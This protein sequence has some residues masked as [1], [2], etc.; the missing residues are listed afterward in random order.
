[1]THNIVFQIFSNINNSIA[2]LFSKTLTNHHNRGADI[3]ILITSD[4]GEHPAAEAICNLLKTY[5]HLYPSSKIRTYVNVKACSAAMYLVLIAD[6]FFCSDFTQF[7]ALDPQFVSPDNMFTVSGVSV[8]EY[9]KIKT[10]SGILESTVLRCKMFNEIASRRFKEFLLSSPIYSKN[11]DAIHKMLYCP[12][13][14]SDIILL[15]Q[16]ETVGIRRTGSVPPEIMHQFNAPGAK[17]MSFVPFLTV[18]VR[19]NRLWCL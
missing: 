16:L 18:P 6:E 13:F 4:G 1:M 7:T 11:A 8:D 19:K 9:A 10:S 5:K 15:K 2:D 17:T 12:D 3:D 14:H